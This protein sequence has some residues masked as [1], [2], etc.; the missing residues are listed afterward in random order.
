[1]EYQQI[2]LEERY[3][4]GKYRCGGHSIRSIAKN[5]GRSPSTISREL[6]RNR[7]ISGFWKA[8]SGIEKSRT[9]RSKSRRK[10]HFSNDLWQIVLHKIRLEW[11]PEQVELW[12]LQNGLRTMSAKTIY[13]RIW[14]EKKEGQTYHHH[15]RQFRKRRRKAYR[16]HDSRGKLAGKCHLSKRPLAADLRMVY[17][18]FEIDLVLGK[19]SKNC[20]LTLV[21]RKTRFTLIQKLEN[22][23]TIV[24]NRAL[25]PLIEK[26]G[27]QTITSDNG[28]EFHG[29]KAVEAATGVKWYFATPHHSWERGTS[30]NTNGLIRQYIPK[31]MNMEKIHPDYYNF[32][33]ERLNNRPKKIL[34]GMTPAEALPATRKSVALHESDRAARAATNIPGFSSIRRST[35]CIP[36][37]SFYR[38]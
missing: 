23:S 35:I 37:E 15:L 29:Y 11:S 21:D 38:H 1:M 8:Q 30:E 34:R 10:T 17:G 20:I 26:Y 27:I 4:I 13:R 19:V 32:I 24:L 6:R 3:L 22:K 36:Q 31:G 5:L 16:S 33:E 28:T 25:I 12:L 9:R 2:T 7:T 14:K 18:H